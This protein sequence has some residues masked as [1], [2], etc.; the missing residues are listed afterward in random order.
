MDFVTSIIRIASLFRHIKGNQQAYI[1]LLIFF[2]PD[3][4]H[5]FSAYSAVRDQENQTRKTSS[6]PPSLIAMEISELR[7]VLLHPLFHISANKGYSLS[8]KRFAFLRAPP[9]AR[10]PFHQMGQPR[11]PLYLCPREQVFQPPLL[12]DGIVSSMD[13]P[14]RCLTSSTPCLL[15][16]AE[17]SEL[18]PILLSL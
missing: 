9:V 1:L 6:T 5:S 7:P 10:F 13:L 2:S 11:G 4:P 17:T 18:S 12:A 16:A 15:A 14:K 8:C 3:P